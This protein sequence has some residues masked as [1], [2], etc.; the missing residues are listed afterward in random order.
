MATAKRST[1][2]RRRIW[3]KAL[4]VALV[5]GLAVGWFYREPIAGYTATGAAFG[6]RTA[7][8]CRYVAGRPIGDCEKD[9]EPGMA[10]V[11]LS[12]DPETKSV[13]ARVPLLSSATAHYRE[14]YGCLL[15][16]WDR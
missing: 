1:G 9:F 16:P 2:R 12:D 15:E 3:P 11:F 6:A 7:C 14:G 8:S 13:T 10:L 4:L 5:L